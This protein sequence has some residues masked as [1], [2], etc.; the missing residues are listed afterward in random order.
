MKVV[1]LVKHVPD[2]AA[3]RLS[4]TGVFAPDMTV[5]RAALTC[6]LDALDENAVEQAMRVARRRLDVQILAVTMGPT[7]ARRSL[8]RALA[9]GADE[10]VHVCDDALHGSDARATSLVLAAVVARVGFDLVVCGAAS[11][12]SG[13]SVVPAMVAERLGVPVAS[14]ADTMWVGEDEVVVRRDADGC[15]EEIAAPLPAVVSV[16]ERAGEPRYPSFRAMVEARQKAVRTWSLADLR[17]G[18]DA[19]GH[20]AAATVVRSVAPYP[21]ERPGLLID[22][23]APDAAARLAGYLT[24]HQLI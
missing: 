1:V 2:E 4:G 20:R 13:M 5:D 10:G 9:L 17:I 8:A 12:D 16:T 23:A 18:P 14:D 21:S 7:G 24:E 11:S 3:D 6:R 15:V 22:G 19:V